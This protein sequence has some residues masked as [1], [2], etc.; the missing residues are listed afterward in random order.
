MSIPCRAESSLR[1][2]RPAAMPAV[3][4]SA[5]IALA[6]AALRPALLAVEPPTETPV[7]APQAAS[8]AKERVDALLD[9]IERT[10][11][12]FESLA[13]DIAVETVDAF[14]DSQEFRSG[15]VV[16]EGRGAA[17]R[18]ALVVD[19]I[20]ID[21][22]TTTAIDHYLFAE[23]WYSRLDHRNRSFTRR[24][25][26]AEGAEPDALES[27]GDQFPLPIGVRKKDILARFDVSE[28][29][30]PADIPL[31]ATLPNATGLRLV[32]KA[33]TAVAEKT[34]AIE[35]FYDRTTVVPVGVVVRSKVAKPEWAKWTAARVAKPVTNGTLSDADRALLVVPTKAPDGWAVVDE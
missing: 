13:G 19:R 2:Y 20:T 4:A 17:R 31:L 29:E 10:G 18:I 6:I 15:R 5:A 30:I 35:V 33:E 14:A 25:L 3:L 22:R 32:P 8:T 21:G 16:V 26:A 7:A 11:A 12:Q 24:R 27:V 9:E 28:A 34:A 1:G 23:G